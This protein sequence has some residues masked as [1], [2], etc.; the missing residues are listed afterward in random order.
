MQVQVKVADE[1]VTIEVYQKSKTVWEAAGYFKG[2]PVTVTK[3]SRAAAIAHW[4]YVA[5]RGSD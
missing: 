1:T 3:R 4:R 5:D 2:H